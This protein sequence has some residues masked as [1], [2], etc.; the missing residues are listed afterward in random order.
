LHRSTVLTVDKQDTEPQTFDVMLDAFAMATDFGK[1][2]VTVEAQR[3]ADD[4]EGPGDPEVLILSPRQALELALRL[5]RVYD[6]AHR[7]GVR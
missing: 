2:A 1:P 4:P 7:G 3:A 6:R 5:L